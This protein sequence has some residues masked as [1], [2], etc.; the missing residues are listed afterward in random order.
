ML[1]VPFE[2][3]EAPLLFCMTTVADLE[4]PMVVICGY[5]SEAKEEG[6]GLGGV[7]VSAG[8]VTFRGRECQSLLYVSS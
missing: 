7:A 3:S 8:A 1:T 2:P 5:G 4:S 6:G